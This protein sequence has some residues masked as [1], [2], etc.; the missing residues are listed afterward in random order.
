MEQ[1]GSYWTDV[2]EFF[3]FEDL[4]KIYLEN[5]SFIEIT[6]ALREDLCTFMIISQFV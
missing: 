4:L 5:T 1:F 2:R 3:I 6:G